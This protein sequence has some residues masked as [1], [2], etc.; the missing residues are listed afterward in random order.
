M[1]GLFESLPAVRL[2]LM[3]AAGRELTTAERA[4]ARQGGNVLS[5]LL[6]DSGPLYEWDHHPPGDVRDPIHGAQYF[7]HAHPAD[8]RPA[9][10]HGHFHTFLRADHAEPL[11]HLVAVAMDRRGRPIRLFTVNRWAT[12]EIWAEAGRVIQLLDRFILDLPQP[13]RWVNRWLAA[14]LR[15][16]R[17]Q[18]EML[19]RQ[20]DAS[21]T[22]W[23]QANPGADAFAARE[24]EVLS[25][26]EIAVPAQI[27]AVAR[28]LAKPRRAMPASS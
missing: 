5:R 22:A 12:E 1:S 3:A 14:L 18:I 24:L 6:R 15:L 13:S 21:I 2:E 17:P 8:Q 19:L 16:Y 23:G 25:E 9:R 20:R 26:M 28:A 11:H 7:Y 4:I 27:D 10:E